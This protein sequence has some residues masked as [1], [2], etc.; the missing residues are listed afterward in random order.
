MEWRRRVAS[1]RLVLAN[2]DDGDIS[3]EVVCARRRAE[4]RR[5]IVMSRDVS[6]AVMT[7]EASFL[8]LAGRSVNS[9]SK[10]SQYRII[11][12]LSFRSVWLLGAKVSLIW[13]GMQIPVCLTVAPTF[14]PQPSTNI[15]ALFQGSSW[16]SEVPYPYD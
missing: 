8:L 5:S 12:M 3:S 14:S 6:Y 2:R 13:P 4:P 7:D 15:P 1:H 16:P 11:S 10:A 9:L